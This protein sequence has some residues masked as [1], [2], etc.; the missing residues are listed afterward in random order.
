MVRDHITCRVA[1]IIGA[2]VSA[3]AELGPVLAS[4]CAGLG[5]RRRHAPRQGL[6]SS[7]FPP[8]LGSPM[9]AGS[10]PTD[11]EGKRT[12]AAGAGARL[13]SEPGETGQK[14]RSDM[15]SHPP[16]CSLGAEAKQL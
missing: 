16:A 14:G 12:T 2:A 1:C 8:G 15:P 7:A 5:Y 9:A 13:V 10:F 3:L 4:S 11:S 6:G